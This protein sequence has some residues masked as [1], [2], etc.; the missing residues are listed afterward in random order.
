MEKK[1]SL[2][3]NNTEQCNGEKPEGECLFG[4]DDNGVSKYTHKN[5]LRKRLNLQI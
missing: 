4:C 3:E 1:N 2:E 5:H